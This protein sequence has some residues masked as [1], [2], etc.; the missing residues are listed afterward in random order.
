MYGGANTSRFRHAEIF[1]QKEISPK[2]NI[3]VFVNVK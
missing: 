1:T 3:I 2:K